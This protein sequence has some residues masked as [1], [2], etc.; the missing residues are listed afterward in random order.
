MP[1]PDGQPVMPGF[2]PALDD[3]TIWSL[4][5][6]LHSNNPNKPADGVPLGMHMHH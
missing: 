4:I 1:G 2:S 3:D 5:D 6:F